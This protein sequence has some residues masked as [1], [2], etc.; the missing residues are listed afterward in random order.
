[1]EDQC[2]LLSINIPKFKNML[3]DQALYDAS[4]S[5]IALHNMFISHFFSLFFF[6]LSSSLILAIYFVEMKTF[7]EDLQAEAE[8]DN[9]QL[10]PIL[11]VEP[12]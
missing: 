11:D 12:S 4:I 1:M 5:H 2:V 3:I 10:G 6:F 9:K 7:V 8:K